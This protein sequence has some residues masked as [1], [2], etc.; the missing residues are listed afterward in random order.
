KPYD[1]MERGNGSGRKKQGN[2]HCYK[3]GARGHMSYDCP[4]KGEKCFSCGRFGHKADACRAKVFCLNCGEEGHK[5]P[6]CRKPR[7]AR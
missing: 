6:T 2:G 3:C 4:S 7:M 5:R 1:V